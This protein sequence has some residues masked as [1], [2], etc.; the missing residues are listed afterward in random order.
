MDK[1]V[2]ISNR[3]KPDHNLL[4]WVNKVFPECE[5]HVVSKKNETVA[6]HPA[7]CSSDRLIARAKDIAHLIKI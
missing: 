7:T 3:S 6:K 5:I 1:I 2:I 4:A